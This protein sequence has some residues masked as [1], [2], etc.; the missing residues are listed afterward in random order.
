LENRDAFL[1]TIAECETEAE[2]KEVKDFLFDNDKFFTMDAD[3]FWHQKRAE[4][5]YALDCGTL[6]TYVYRGKKG[7][8]AR[9]RKKK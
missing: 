4:Q 6:K 3:G 7:S 1:K 8:D 2:W 5:D 9:W